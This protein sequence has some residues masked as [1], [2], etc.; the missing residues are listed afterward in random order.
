VLELVEGAGVAAG[1]AAGAVVGSEEEEE[2][3][4]SV[5]V[6]EAA[7]S[8]ERAAAR[9]MRAARGWGVILR[10][11]GSRPLSSASSFWREGFKFYKIRCTAR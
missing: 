6:A 9:S 5:E 7:R 11:L 8:D 10:R 4:T 1:A 3:E 2:E